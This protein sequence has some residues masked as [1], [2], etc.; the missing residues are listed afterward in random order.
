MTGHRDSGRSVRGFTLVE[1]MVALAVFSITIGGIWGL[2]ATGASSTRL[3]D[4]FLQVQENAR[5]AMERLVEEGR[6]ASGISSATG[7]TT[8]SVTLSIPANNP[9]SASAYTVTY[10]LTSSQTITRTV[11]GGTASQLAG[12]ITGLTFTYYDNAVPADVLTVSNA[13]NAWRFTVSVTATAGQQ[14]RT[15]TT[16]VFLRNK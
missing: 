4:N 6:W 12:D 7:G 9:A 1:M 10:A 16:D 15:F 13:A 5:Y 8:P 14:T 11:N 3:T 2:L